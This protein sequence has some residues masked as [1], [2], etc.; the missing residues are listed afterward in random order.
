MT[1]FTFPTR[2]ALRA[3]LADNCLSDE[4]IWILFQKKKS[5]VLTAAEALEEALCF[6]WIDGQMQCVDDD[7]YV[8]YFRQRA[9]GSAWSEKNKKLCAALEES[10]RMTN[11]GRAKILYAK[12]HG[13]WDAPAKPVLTEDS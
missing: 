7:T 10:G 2:A 8:K 6:G 12:E 13:S 9:P 4:G 5:G 11:Y 1:T 3:W